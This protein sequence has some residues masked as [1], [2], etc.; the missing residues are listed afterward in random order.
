MTIS[1]HSLRIAMIWL[2]LVVCMILHFD[3]HVSELFYGID[4]KKP[5]ANGTVPNSILIIR[6]IFHFLPFGFILV[7][8]WTNN[9]IWRKI[10]IGIAGIYTLAHGF[11]LSGELSKGDN[12]SQILLLATTFLISVFLIIAC[13]S[14]VKNRNKTSHKNYEPESR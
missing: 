6:G 11:H 4:I 12:P 9:S 2:I 1:T 7:N 8:L 10:Q 5:D 14:S 3:Y 13:I